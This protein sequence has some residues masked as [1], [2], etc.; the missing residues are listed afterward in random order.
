MGDLAEPYT[1]KDLHEQRT[2]F[3]EYG[4]SFAFRI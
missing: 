2:A 3:Q 1:L 4:G